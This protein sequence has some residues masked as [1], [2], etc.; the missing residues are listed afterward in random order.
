MSRHLAAKESR[1]R[2][3]GTFSF[4]VQRW[5][6]CHFNGK[7]RGSPEKKEYFGAGKSVSNVAL[8]VLVTVTCRKL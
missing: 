3:E 5:T 4:Q 8:K 2:D 1:M 6:E 7:K